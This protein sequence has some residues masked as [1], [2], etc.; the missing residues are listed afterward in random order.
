MRSKHNVQVEQLNEQLDQAKRARGALDK[1]KAQLESQN[2][3]LAGEVKQLSVGK[4]E[5]ERKRKQLD[6]QQ[7]ETAMKL[8]ELERSKA[9]VGEKLL[10]YKVSGTRG[11]HQTAG[12]GK[13]QGRWGWK[14]TQIQGDWIK[15]P[16]SNCRNW[17]EARQ[18]GVMNYSNTRWVE[19]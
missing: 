7:Q 17:R 19:H 8:Q 6:Q 5:S 2:A 3:E 1:T 9:D 18:M 4:Q 15:R 16:P 12:T 11:L 13:E 14:T 10:K